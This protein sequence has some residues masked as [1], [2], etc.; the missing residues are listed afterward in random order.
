MIHY[1]MMIDGIDFGTIVRYLRSPRSGIQCLLHVREKS[2]LVPLAE[3]IARDLE[4]GAFKDGRCPPSLE[5]LMQDG[6]LKLSLSEDKGHEHAS[7][8]VSPSSVSPSARCQVI[9]LEPFY[10]V[11]TPGLFGREHECEHPKTE[12]RSKEASPSKT[13]TGRQKGRTHEIS[14]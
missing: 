1:E 11:Y 5:R 2:M 6:S 13:Q 10:L 14:H 7:Y 8:Y 4:S 9:Y 3:T 12:T